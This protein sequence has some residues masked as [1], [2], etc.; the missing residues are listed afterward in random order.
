MVCFNVSIILAGSVDH[1]FDLIVGR[2]V[3]G[4]LVRN[5][6]HVEWRSLNS[7]SGRGRFHLAHH[8]F[9]AAAKGDESVKTERRKSK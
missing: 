7:A 5:E 2:S 4:S 1:L 6:T 9:T 8:N 3:S